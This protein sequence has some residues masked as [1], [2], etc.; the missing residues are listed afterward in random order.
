MENS[1][2]NETLDKKYLLEKVFDNYD[3]EISRKDRLQSKVI[4]YYT[5]LGIYFAAFLV[6]EPL[7]F[8]RHFVVN[9]S[10]WDVLSVVNIILCIVFL[11]LMCYSIY[12]MH[13]CYKIQ[14]R[15]AF[16]PVGEWDKLVNMKDAEARENIKNFLFNTIREYNNSNDEIVK[17]LKNT[18]TRVIICSVIVVLS[19]ILC[20]ILSIFNPGGK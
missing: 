3:A 8:E 6:I 12:G 2:D 19:F 5:I 13:K 15:K 9:L 18:D 14:Y 20:S 11:V 7:F 10:L 4:G 17:V 1:N 16:D